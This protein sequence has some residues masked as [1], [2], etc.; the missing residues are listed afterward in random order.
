MTK[1]PRV[2]IAVCAHAIFFC[3]GNI[4]L[5]VEM[6]IHFGEKFNFDAQQIGLQFIAIIIGCILGEQLSGPLSDWS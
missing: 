3:Y 1:H 5:I 6:P 4:A 2:L